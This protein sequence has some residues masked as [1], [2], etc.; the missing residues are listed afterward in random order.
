M[1]LQAQPRK[2]KWG[3]NNKLEIGQESH[4]DCEKNEQ[5]GSQWVIILENI[6][7]L[8]DFFFVLC[9]VLQLVQHIRKACRTIAFIVAL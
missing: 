8:S 6:W 2:K 3:E 7:L 9:F 1:S 5:V 4:Y